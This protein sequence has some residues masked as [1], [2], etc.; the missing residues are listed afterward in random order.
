MFKDWARPALVPVAFKGLLLSTA[1]SAI[2]EQVAAHGG[3]A[4]LVVQEAIKG[5]RVEG[6]TFK[7]GLALSLQKHS[8]CSASSAEVVQSRVQMTDPDRVPQGL[9]A[10]RYWGCTPCTN[11]GT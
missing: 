1:A 2:L 11:R 3:C 6:I 10:G 8:V 9:P 7:A 4:P 5:L